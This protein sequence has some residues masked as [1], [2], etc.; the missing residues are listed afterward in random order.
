ML[1]GSSQSMRCSSSPA[2]CARDLHQRRTNLSLP[3]TF[4]SSSATASVPS[5]LLSSTITTSQSETPLQT[6]AYDDNNSEREERERERER[7]MYTRELLC[8]CDTTGKP[9]AT[10]THTSLCVACTPQLYIYI[11]VCVCVCAYAS[12]NPRA[13]RQTM[14]GRFSLSLYV[15]RIT[16]N[17]EDVAGAIFFLMSSSSSSSSSLSLSLTPGGAPSGRLEREQS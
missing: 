1:D 8:M 6:N 5:G 16:E 4:C 2:S 10:L 9:L 7:E 15:G 17:E 12:S 13:M 14:S 3:Y 11:C